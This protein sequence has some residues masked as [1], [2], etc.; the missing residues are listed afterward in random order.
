MLTMARSYLFAP[1]NKEDLLSKVFLAGADAVVLD[2]EDA[3]AE[4][5]KER[6]RDRVRWALH[7]LAPQSG[8]PAWVRINGLAS[9]HW[10]ADLRAVV[11]PGLKGIRLAKAEQPED[12]ALLEKELARLESAAGLHPGSLPLA[13]T[14]ESAKG[15]LRAYELASHPRASH[16]ALGATDFVA[17]IAADPTF[18]E[19]TLWARSQLVV[20]ARAAGIAPPIAS[21]HTA[22]GDREGLLRTT[23]DALRLGFFGRSAIH[24]GQ[25]PA[26]HEVFTPNADEVARARR[27]VEAF[28]ETGEGVSTLADGSFLD[29]A[30]VRRARA[31]LDLVDRSEDAD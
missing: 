18:G 15:V 30:V 20:A 6:A 28:A 11:G 10:R 24:P 7:E 25:L 8:C 26:I 4:G 2:L 17:D 9:G 19:A 13:C 21:V 27:V 14:I 29:A 12:L 23:R 5:E 1:G 22:L 16:L 3:V 31:I